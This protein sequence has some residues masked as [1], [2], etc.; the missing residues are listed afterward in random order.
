[1]L[2]YPE[3]KARWEEIVQQWLGAIAVG[4]TGRLYIFT[5][6]ATGTV[7]QVTLPEVISK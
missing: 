4:G 5:K 2:E 7:V 3:L 6:V 1:M